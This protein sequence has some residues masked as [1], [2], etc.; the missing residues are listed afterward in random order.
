M[1]GYQRYVAYVYE[2]R[3]GKKSQN[4]GFIK[5]EVRDNLCRMEI[6]LQCPGL[7]PQVQCRIYGFVRNSGLID[8]ILLGTG[9]TKEGS[10]QCAL[11]LNSHDMNNSGVPLGKFGGMILK[12]ESGAFFGTEWD[13][14]VIRPE[15]FRERSAQKKEEVS[16]KQ[17]VI[18]ETEDAVNVSTQS[19]Q[20]TEV[21]ELPRPDVSQTPL[22]EPE[23]AAAARSPVEPHCVKQLPQIGV[24]F[25]PFADGEISDTRKIQLQDISNFPCRDCTLKQ[26]RFLMHGYMQFGHLMIGQMP[27]GC[28]MIGVPGGYNQQ[29]HFMANMFGFPYFKE[30]R[31][32]QIPSGKGGY[33]YRLINTANLN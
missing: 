15:N 10:I 13:D 9:T 28:Y 19:L 18:S 20:A 1:A 7:T 6:N 4:C 27:S 29:E 21:Q 30:S 26:N 33:W 5:V 16:E 11:E 24:P 25:A 8:G 32:I 31:S 14:Q 12:T 23:T 22:S 3:K 17:Q 2:Y